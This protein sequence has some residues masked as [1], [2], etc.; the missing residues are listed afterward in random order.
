MDA[1]NL[2]LKHSMNYV[3]IFYLRIHII[4]YQYNVNEYNNKKIS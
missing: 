4:M 1:F 2:K 3:N